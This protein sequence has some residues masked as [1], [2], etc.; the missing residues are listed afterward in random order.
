MT[1]T[2]LLCKISE[3]RSALYEK[4]NEDMLMFEAADEIKIGTSMYLCGIYLTDK[5]SSLAIAH[6]NDTQIPIFLDIL[7]DDVLLKI[8][9]NLRKNIK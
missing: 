7:S 5:D 3:Y 9:H 2:S 6:V 1:M 4:S 8:T